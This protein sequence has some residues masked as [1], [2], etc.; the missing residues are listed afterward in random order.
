MKRTITTLILLVYIPAAGY[1]AAL[2]LDH[3]F[4]RY[5]LARHG[6]ELPEM[7]QYPGSSKEAPIQ[8]AELVNDNDEA[9]VIA[10]KLRIYMP[11]VAGI[12]Q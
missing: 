7:L 8:Q 10:D 6:L 4:E 12:N 2:E 9:D 5:Y 11:K 1:F 3:R